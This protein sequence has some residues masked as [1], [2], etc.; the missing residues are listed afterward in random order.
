MFLS[1]T[2]DVSSYV[3]IRIRTSLCSLIQEP[4]PI[5]GITIACTNENG[6]NITV[7]W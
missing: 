6:Y 2:L 4:F 7:L 1:F 3:A 5:C